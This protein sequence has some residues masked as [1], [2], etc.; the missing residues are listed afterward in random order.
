MAFTCARA[1]PTISVSLLGIAAVTKRFSIL[2]SKGAFEAMRTVQGYSS[3]VI[4]RVIGDG[5]GLHF[6]PG[7]QGPLL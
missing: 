7:E 6:S 4:V 3:D 1:I 5:I 2:D